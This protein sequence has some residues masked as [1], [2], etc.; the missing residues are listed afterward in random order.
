M[1]ACLHPQPRES[2]DAL[3]QRFI[4]VWNQDVREGALLLAGH[5]A[6]PH[7]PTP[8]LKLMQLKDRNLVSHST[9]PPYNTVPAKKRR[10]SQAR[11]LAA[12]LQCWL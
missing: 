2:A 10:S 1:Q 4:D 8:A 12:V 6:R 11:H 5:D 3:L 7:D 9:P